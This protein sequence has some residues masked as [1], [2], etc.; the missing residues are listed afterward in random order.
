MNIIEAPFNLTGKIVVDTFDTVGNVLGISDSDHHHN[1]HHGHHHCVDPVQAA[2]L[3]QQQ[4]LLEQ[5]ER[6]AAA[7]RKAQED[8][9]NRAFVEDKNREGMAFLQRKDGP[10]A[11]IQFKAALSR[12]RY[13]V[14]AISGARL[15]YELIGDTHAK[16]GDMGAAL[17]VYA[18]AGAETKIQ[19]IV[20]QVL[21]QHEQAETD[22]D[23]KLQ[24]SSIEEVDTALANYQ[25]IKRELSKLKKVEDYCPALSQK[26]AELKQKIQH[27]EG[28]KQK[29]RGIT[30]ASKT[31]EQF[32]KFSKKFDG[33]FGTTAELKLFPSREVAEQYIEQ[34]EDIRR[35]YLEAFNLFGKP[36]EAERYQDLQTLS[37]NLEK[38][39][40]ELKI[41]EL[42]IAMAQASNSLNH[43]SLRDEHDLQPIIQACDLWINSCKELLRLSPDLKQG[44]KEMQE[45]ISTLR[46]KVEMLQ[47]RMKSLSSDLYIELINPIIQIS[48]SDGSLSAEAEASLREEL[49]GFSD[50]AAL[51]KQWLSLTPEGVRSVQTKIQH[52]FTPFVKKSGLCCFGSSYKVKSHIPLSLEMLEEWLNQAERNY[53]TELD[54]P[55]LLGIAPPAYSSSETLTA[56]PPP[57]AT[58]QTVDDLSSFQNNSD[59]DTVQKLNKT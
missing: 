44:H 39:K 3:A 49:K 53:K 28:K 9:E 5:Q 50:N 34:I 24:L 27:A 6:Q 20:A 57:Y 12:D 25:M 11:L 43:H 23:T 46:G 40:T 58:Y 15:A 41:D 59:F 16:A 17:N 4:R 13:N 26:L 7:D 47:W 21:K 10:K 19:K 35:G 51:R 30:L 33:I 56:L 38:K 55:Q 42:K 29:L 32:Q 48:N 8:R 37:K 52:F 14:E 2:M 18:Q 45:K 31:N 36:F 22:A 1:G 54:I